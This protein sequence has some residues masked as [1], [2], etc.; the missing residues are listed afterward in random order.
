MP[1]RQSP[2]PTACS[3]ISSAQYEQFGAHSS[4]V[5]RRDEASGMIGFEFA[6]GEGAVIF[7]FDARFAGMNL[8]LPMDD[9]WPWPDLFREGKASLIENIRKVPAFALR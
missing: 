6:F 3:A 9:F 8:R 5:W 4:S 1:W 2:I 7:K